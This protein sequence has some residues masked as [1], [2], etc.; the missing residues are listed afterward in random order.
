LITAQK[1]QSPFFGCQIGC[2]K[3]FDHQIVLLKNIGHKI[4]Q[5][6][7]FNHH[8]GQLENLTTANFQSFDQQ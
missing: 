3:N 8:I 2:S 5:S 6:K 7:N 4:G 1:I